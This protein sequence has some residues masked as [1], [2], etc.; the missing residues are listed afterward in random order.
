[1]NLSFLANHKRIIVL[2]FAVIAAAAGIYAAV[3]H[4][5]ASDQ[6]DTYEYSRT[7]FLSKGELNE[8]V[9]V[10]GTI[11]SAQVSSVTTNLSNKVVDV[12]V[13]VGDVVKKGDIICTLDDSDIKKAIEDKKKELSEEKQKLQDNYNKAVKQLEEAKK[14]KESENAVQNSRIVSAKNLL[15]SANS[16]ADSVTPMYNNAKA[17]YDTMLKAVS[18]AQS[19]YD[20]ADKQLQTAY[21][22][23][24]ASGGKT[25]GEEYT[26]YQ[27]AQEA[28]NQ[29]QEELQQAKQL[30]SFEKYTE[31]FNSAKQTYDSAVQAKSE[32]QSNFDQVNLGAK[33]ALD[34]CDSAI[35]SAVSLVQEADRELKKGVSSTALAELE[36][37]LQET[38]L[39]AETS[40][41]VTDLKVNVGS[42][43]KGEIAT[44]Q[45]TDNLI[46]SV[47][48]PEYAIEKVKPDMKAKITSDAVAGTLTGKVTRISPTASA[49]DSAPSGGFSADITLDKSDGIFIGSKAKAEIIISSK[50]DVFT[51]PLDAVGENE[52]GESVIYVKSGDTFQPLAVT[53]GNKNDYSVEISSS[54]LKEDMEVLA[55]ASAEIMQ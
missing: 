48:I 47:L 26:A 1:M 42:I 51:V 24:I 38:V 17:N 16:V 46:I 18:E 49:G 35:N 53:T 8:T 37:S 21:N 52:K 6:K 30:Y 50:S 32:A 43:C 2:A 13:K 29:K 28:L 7:V 39:K 45:S 36:K 55:D 33:Q 31:E 12:K 34:S 27:S 44:I 40:G 20:N 23:W 25:E 19:Q 54:Q 9:N 41:K 3:S 15:D 14:A 5:K 10:S 4:N 11:Q 22:A